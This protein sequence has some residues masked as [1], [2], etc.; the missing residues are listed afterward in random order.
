[1][2][3]QKKI[4]KK[5]E[6]AITNFENLINPMTT[7]IT[8]KDCHFL[9]CNHCLFPITFSVR[10]TFSSGTNWQDLGSLGSFCR[11]DQTGTWIETRSDLE[12]LTEGEKQNTVA[13]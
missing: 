9:Q 11:E 13:I 12:T 3:H 1:M 6:F 10:D 4:A 2:I 7:I 8:F 5:K